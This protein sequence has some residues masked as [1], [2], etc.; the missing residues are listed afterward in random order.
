MRTAPESLRGIVK[1]LMEKDPEFRATDETLQ[2]DFVDRKAKEICTAYLAGAEP[3]TGVL[4]TYFGETCELESIIQSIQAKIDD[5]R[6]R[7]LQSDE[8]A[9]LLNGMAGGYIPPG[10][11]GIITRG[12]ARYPSDRQE[13]LL[14]RSS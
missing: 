6:T 8:T 4:K 1:G 5:V 9:A 14:P 7:V 2:K 10:P 13:F 12:R 3:L 11:S